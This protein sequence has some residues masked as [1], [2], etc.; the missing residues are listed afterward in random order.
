MKVR[1]ASVK[2]KAV[3]EETAFEKEVNSSSPL[4]HSLEKGVTLSTFSPDSL[5]APKDTTNLSIEQQFMDE[6]IEKAKKSSPIGTEKTWGSKVYINAG[7]G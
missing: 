7:I 4:Q 3:S 1:K 6:I 5:S 2:R